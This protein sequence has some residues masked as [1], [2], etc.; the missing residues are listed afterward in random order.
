MPRT[1]S[2]RVIFVFH[3]RTLQGQKE[4]VALQLTC[5][6]LRS[7]CAAN[8]WALGEGSLGAVGVL[9]EAGGFGDPA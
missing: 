6:G 5:F 2:E 4:R 8:V 7:N 1:Q 9:V 3:N